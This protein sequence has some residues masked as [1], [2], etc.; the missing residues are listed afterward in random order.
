[1]PYR[2]E[3][4]L[5]GSSQLSLLAR[6]QQCQY[7][8]ARQLVPGWTGRLINRTTA[9]L[10]SVLFIRGDSELILGPSSRNE[11]VLAVRTS[12]RLERATKLQPFQGTLRTDKIDISDTINDDDVSRTVRE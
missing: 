6:Q 4:H 11:A 9:V 10:Y 2:S 3:L 1:M 5:P 8:Y 12:Q 7:I